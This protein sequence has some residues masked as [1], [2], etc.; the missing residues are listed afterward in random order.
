MTTASP[1][2][3]EAAGPGQ[4]VV[5]WTGAH[6]AALPPEMASRTVRFGR[7]LVLI[8]PDGVVPLPVEAAWRHAGVVSP[9]RLHL[10]VDPRGDLSRDHPEAE[11]LYV[12]GRY[13]IV[14]ADPAAAAHWT[15][16]RYAVRRLEIPSTV[17][18]VW[19][20]PPAINPDP[21]V[22]ALLK[23]VS[24][25][26]L[27]ADIDALVSFTT[28]ESTRPEYQAAAR[29][30][31]GRFEDMGY[32]NRQV[33]VIDVEGLPSANVIVTVRGSGPAPRPAVFVTAHLDSIGSGPGAPA[34]GA[35]DNAS[36]V[37][38]VLEIARHLAHRVPITDL[39]FVLF[40]GE[41][42]GLLGS[43]HFL[44]STLRPASIQC[45]VNMDMIGANTC[46]PRTVMVEGT[47]LSLPMVTG[48]AAAAFT[49]TPLAVQVVT[50][51]TA[52]SLSDNI[53]FDNRG[54]AAVLLIE[55]NGSTRQHSIDDVTQYIDAPLVA[56]IVRTALAFIVAE[57]RI[58]L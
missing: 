51:A 34:P 1:Q 5:I 54:L 28:R 13:A 47:G 53:A 22:R 58:P 30:A 19:R 32:V 4:R 18:E 2:G 25:A 33:Q 48:I 57:C 11:V 7:Q 43:H 26:R 29:W 44:D 10:V 56:D 40:G 15:G 36:G 31:L 38:G 46:G 12:N 21:A 45:A 41:E 3:L 35:D 23:D 27:E 50:D 49:Y 42:Q 52:R 24:A 14:D 9:S 55:G 16:P 39:V 6:E 20:R 8:A 17:Y 37:A